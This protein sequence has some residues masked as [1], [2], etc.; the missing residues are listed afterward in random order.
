MRI[1]IVSFFSPPANAPG[2]IRIGKLAQYLVGAGHDVRLLAGRDLDC[3]QISPHEATGDVITDVIPPPMPWL[4]RWLAALE[5]EYRRGNLRNSGWIRVLYKYYRAFFCLPDRYISWYLRAAPAG[6]RLLREWRPDVIYASALPITSLIVAKTLAASREIPW[7][8]EM[9]DLWVD[10]HYYDMP[11]WRRWI[12]SRIEAAC[13]GQASALVTVSEPLAE[14]LRN[15]YRKPTVS[16]LNG[17]DTEDIPVVELD[18]AHDTPVS[19]VYTGLVYPKQRDPSLLFEALAGMG[20]MRNDFRVNFYGNLMPEVL[21]LAEKHGVNDIVR[22]HPPVPH[23]EALRR[24][25]EADILLLL[26]WNN[27]GE[28]GVF[29]SKLF[30]YLAA[31]RP[32]L[33]LGCTTGV[34]ADEIRQRKA[35]AVLD[36]VE[37]IR[38]WLRAMCVQKRSEGMV[39]PLP[40][41]V[42]AHISRSEQFDKLLHTILEPIYKKS[43]L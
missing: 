22:A 31:R 6:R 4:R 16:I 12:D 13:L 14:V 30:E 43:G 35:G 2:A 23:A 25:A 10:S 38:T 40:K 19:I 1:L 3:P 33:C 39:P 18:K 17:I 27:K 5:K 29:T 42:R 26:L 41:E 24:Q 21:H 32:I 37:D 8:A 9:R 11:A 7:V 28:T 36:T 15:K 34:A 20:E